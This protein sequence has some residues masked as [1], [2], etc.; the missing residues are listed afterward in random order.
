MESCSICFEKIKVK[1][2]LDC[3]HS[4]CKTCIENW[5]TLQITCPICRRII[6]P[7]NLEP[8]YEGFFNQKLYQN[9]KFLNFLLYATRKHF[10]SYIKTGEYYKNK[11]LY[12]IA[13]YNSDQYYRELTIKLN[14]YRQKVN[15]YIFKKF[16]F[17]IFKKRI[18]F[19]LSSISRRKLIS[20]IL[21]MRKELKLKYMKKIR[22]QNYYPN[23]DK[24]D[25]NNIIKR[26][27]KQT[28]EIYVDFNKNDNFFQCINNG[29]YSENERNN[30][31][32]IYLFYPVKP[33]LEIDEPI[34]SFQNDLFF[35]RF[36]ITLEKNLEKNLY[37]YNENDYEQDCKFYL[38]I[39]K[40]YTNN[41]FSGIFNEFILNKR[42]HNE[43]WDFVKKLILESR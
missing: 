16:T 15:R 20:K 14:C 4:F 19:L 17:S 33:N 25:K 40:N 3:S 12:K 27:K 13:K 22:L 36:C 6:I 18:T 26:F 21:E 5:K 9:E 7:S 30:I 1:V 32:N 43:Q 34:P 37:K 31:N 29:F 11:R 8:T 2:H 41:I 38:N 24:V 28:L 35:L 39:H 42:Y 23:L 10:Q